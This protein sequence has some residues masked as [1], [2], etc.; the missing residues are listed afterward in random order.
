MQ[1]GVLAAL[2]LLL[3]L[4]ACI[5]VVEED[6]DDHDFFHRTRWRLDVVVYHGRAYEANATYTVSFRTDGEL[7]GRADCND[8][9]GTFSTPRE[10]SLVIRDIYSSGDVCGDPSMENDYF[11]VLSGAVAYRVRGDELLITARNG[12]TLSFFKD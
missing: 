7:N 3:F 8:Y 10:G 1:K 9:E 2:M 12:D 5:L 11:E 4:P 6:D